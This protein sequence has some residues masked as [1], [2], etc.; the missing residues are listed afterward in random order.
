MS[1]PED[2]SALDVGGSDERGLVIL[3]SVEDKIGNVLNEECKR[4]FREIRK[5]KN[6]IEDL[7]AEELLQGSRRGV[8][9]VNGDDGYPYAVPVNYFYDRENQRIYFHGARAGHK[10]DALRA[11]DKVCFTVYGNEMIKEEDWAPFMQSVVVFGRC[12]LLES[13]CEKAMEML[14]RFA[15]KYYPNEE[16]VDEEIAQAGRA[17]QMFEIEIEHLSGKE[18]QEK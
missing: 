2:S 13:G 4:M 9:A 18:V 6:K 5:K 1:V 10:V 11:C 3:E 7:A 16:L 17:V 8:L 15:M 12:H 14:K